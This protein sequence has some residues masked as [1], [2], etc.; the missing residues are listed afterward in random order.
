M[1]PKLDLSTRAYIH[2][3]DIYNNALKWTLHMAS[4]IRWTLHIG[5]YM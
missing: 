1:P 2:G 5:P 3:T 4:Y